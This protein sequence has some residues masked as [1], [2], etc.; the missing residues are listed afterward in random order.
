MS[1]S[2]KTTTTAHSTTVEPRRPEDAPPAAASA[3]QRRGQTR[4][5]RFAAALE[6]L[7]FEIVSTG[8]TAKTLRAR[9]LAVTDVAAITAFPEI[10]DG[11]VKTLH[12]HIHGGLL[13]RRGVDD[14]VLATHGIGVIDLLVVNLYPF[15]ATTARPDCTDAEAIENIDVGGP[16]M[17]R[18]AA[19]N[20]EHIT[21]VVDHADYESVLAA[22]KD[23]GV[24]PAMR[25]QLAIKAFGHT[26]RYDTAISILAHAQYRRPTTGR[27]RCYEAGISCSRCATARTRIS[28]QRCTARPST[29]RAR[30]ARAAG[31]GQGAVVQQPRRR[32]RRVS[33][34]Q[35]V[36]R[37]GVCHR[38]AREPVR[39]CDGGHSRHRVSARLPRR[40][41]LRVRRRHR[42]QP[43][44]RDRRRRRS[45]A[46]SSPKSSSRP[47]SAKPPA[48]RSRKAGHSGARGGLA[49]RVVCA[50]RRASS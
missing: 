44:A 38:E 46:S 29:C 1:P 15:E 36:R 19:K 28:A 9:G 5:H 30:R 27:I 8:G 3:T 23:G 11:R 10:M 37:R 22:L 7:G 32:R 2:R 35:G 31:T 40:S 16:A 47:R 20:H 4:A 45:S 12:P 21:V 25:R 39:H 13:A 17:L 6:A 41:D 42:I 49:D 26:A 43:A 50:A 48:Q 33:S 24:P 14:A 18:A 34:R